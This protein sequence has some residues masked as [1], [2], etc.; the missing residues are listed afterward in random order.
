MTSYNLYESD[1]DPKRDS[2]IPF[3]G[4]DGFMQ[5]M[6]VEDRSMRLTP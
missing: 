3:D 2:D 5:G 1:S 4:L 6:D